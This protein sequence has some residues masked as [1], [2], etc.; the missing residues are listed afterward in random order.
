MT[1]SALPEEPLHLPSIAQGLPPVPPPAL[2]PYLDAAAL[3]FAR[4]G[5]GRT[6]VPDIA[7][8]LVISRT[9]VYRQVGTVERAARLLLARELHA[10]LAQLPA[11]LDGATGPETVTRLIA[12]IVQLAREHPVLAKVLA[13]ERELIG[14][15]LTGD[16]LPELVAR[17]ATIAA[18]LLELAMT[19]G[20]IRARPPGVLAE[21][22]VRITIS[23]VLAPP[24]SGIVPFLDETVL[25][26]LEPA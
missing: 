7:R 14:Q 5:I 3:C 26:V 8:E 22:L 4:H 25:A 18:P 1:G 17:V 19:A 24:P 6:G 13:D 15:F 12:T 10:L 20:L 2:D 9:T 23:L 11:I 21:F 16:E